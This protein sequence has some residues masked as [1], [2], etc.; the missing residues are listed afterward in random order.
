MFTL[1]QFFESVTEIWLIWLASALSLVYLTRAALSRARKWDVRRLAHGEE[2][3]S[4]VLSVVLVMP[5]YIF[6]VCLIVECT[7]MLV[8]KTGTM[9]A[10][11]AA[12]RSAIV[13]VPAEPNDEDEALE[14]ARSAAVQ[15]MVPFATGRDVHRRG[16]PLAVQP[17]SVDGTVYYAAYKL[18]T[19]GKAP[20]DYVVKKFQ[21]ADMATTVSI[22]DDPDSDAFNEE[23][24]VTVTYEMPLNVPVIGRWLGEQPT[25][26]LAPFYTRKISTTVVLEKEG[27]QSQ[28]QLLGIKY[29]SS[30]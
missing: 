7:L 20:F 30:I 14:K 12:S 11:Y 22:D 18:Y 9:Y 3:A 25:W 17:V 27:P 26:L 6:L 23:L 29:D 16:T 1:Q 24:A 10:A 2:G 5:V 15:A 4:Y 13:W 8:V 19:G 28:N 21:Y